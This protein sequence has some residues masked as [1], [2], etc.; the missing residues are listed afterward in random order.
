MTQSFSDKMLDPAKR[1]ATVK[2]LFEEKL[3]KEIDSEDLMGSISLERLESD[4]LYLDIEDPIREQEIINQF[5]DEE[6]SRYQ[7]DH[8]KVNKWADDLSGEEDEDHPGPYSFKRL[9]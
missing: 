3:G 9:S 8:Q 7:N 2:K 1:R 6:V 5:V 4:L